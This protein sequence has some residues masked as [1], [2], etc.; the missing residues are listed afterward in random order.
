MCRCHMV[1]ALDNK[2]AEEDMMCLCQ[3]VF[4]MTRLCVKLHGYARKCYQV[5]VIINQISK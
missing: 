2:H 3:T 5:D 4:G 1:F